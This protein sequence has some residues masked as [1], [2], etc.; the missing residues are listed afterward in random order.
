MCKD[1]PIDD[2][3]NV[4][5]SVKQKYCNISGS[6][7]KNESNDESRKRNELVKNISN[8]KDIN[9]VEESN[10]DRIDNDAG[11]SD[12]V[13]LYRDMKD[14]DADDFEILSS[15]DYEVTENP[16]FHDD[17]SMDQD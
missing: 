10:E 12:E 13:D 1:E 11:M 6:K 16:L 7:S 8:N 4:F 14:E 17:M 2:R 3:L 15:T 9:K 5:K